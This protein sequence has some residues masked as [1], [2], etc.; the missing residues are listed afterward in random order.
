MDTVA[1][2]GHG[3]RAEGRQRPPRHR[4]EP[5][6]GGVPAVPEG[7]AAQPGRPGTGP[8]ATA[9]CCPAATSRI[10]L[11]TQLFLGGFGLELED[12]KAL[13]TWGSKTP[14]H[15]EYGHTAG[16]ETTTGPLGQGV[17]QR[18][19]HGDG[20]P[21][22]ARPARPRT[23]P[24]ATRR[25]T[26]TSTRS[27]RDGD[28][29]EGVSAE[30]SSLA[31]TQQ[32]GNLT[33]IYDANQISIEDDTDIAFTED[34]AQALRGLRLA[35]PDRRLDQRRHR[36][37][38]RTCPQLYAAIR[39]PPRR[40]PTGPASSCCARSSPGP[41]PT[42]R[43]PARPHGSALGADEVAAT[44]EILGFDPEQTFE[45]ADDVLAHTRAAGRA[46]PGGPGAPGRSSSTRWAPQ[47]V[48]RRRRCSSGCS[49]R[50]AA[51][52][53][54]RRAADVRGRRQGRRDPRGLRRGHQR[55]APA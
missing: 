8:A 6:A 14:G 31:G 41:P 35:R 26:T 10:T 43:A 16:V 5:G 47:A 22:R 45:V 7:D 28:L 1:G 39:R 9:S 30:A 18:R 11:Y 49:T 55:A 29:E 23:P 32:L 34:V 38:S 48:G 24:R 52:R 51:R 15:P 12:L 36:R 42:R 53:L 50:T 13:R 2:P 21:P 20:R 3:R 40:S 33:L 54:G 27:A 37:T 44:K 17:A 19:R 4:D 25:S 46:R